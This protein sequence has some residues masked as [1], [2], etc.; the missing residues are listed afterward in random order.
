MDKIVSWLRKAWAAFIAAPVIAPLLDLLRHRS[1][2][3][4]I[5]G[6]VGYTI[7]P[8]IQGLPPMWRDNLGNFIF[9]GTLLVSGRFTLE[10]ILTAKAGLPQTT[11]EY[12]RDLLKELISPTPDAT[13]AAQAVIT[14]KWQ[15]V[16]VGTISSGIA[17]NTGTL[18]APAP[19]TML[20]PDD[21]AANG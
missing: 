3:V 20:A 19:R 2:L 11:E 5:A 1:V 17:D 4:L 10:G 14:P 6:F 7:V 13:V 12:L 8:Q 15:A 16:T 18:A 9:V 21:V